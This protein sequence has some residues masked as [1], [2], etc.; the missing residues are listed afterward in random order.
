MGGYRDL[1]V[2]E[3]SYAA[4]R[5]IYKITE[6]FPKEEIY[7][8]TNQMRRAS[9][10]ISLNIAEGYAKRESQIEFK[11]FLMMAVGSANEMSVL[12]DFAKDFEYIGKDV[13]EKAAAE[14]EEIC[15][16]LHTLI[17][18]VGAKEVSNVMTKKDIEQDK[19]RSEEER[20]KRDISN[21][22]SIV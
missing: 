1:K 15:R 16:M 14:Y 6:R 21:L 8:M 19:D 4:A 10:S 2:Y 5:A 18:K 12:I 13:H 17:K 22:I 7:G 20:F 9:I 3:R 11:R